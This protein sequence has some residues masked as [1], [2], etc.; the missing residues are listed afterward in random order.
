MLLSL[1]GEI[2]KEKGTYRIIYALPFLSIT[3]QVEEICKEIFRNHNER[4]ARIDSKSENT[5]FA[6][7][8]KEMDKNP[9]AISKIINAQFAE[10]LFDYPFI[11]TTFVKVFE[12]I[13]S[14][15]NSTL[16]KLPNFS[17]TIFLIDEIQSIPPRLYGFFVALLN[18][19]C[20]KFDSY[21]ILSTATMPNFE[22][23]K[24]NQHNLR[25]LFYNFS[26]PTELVSMNYFQSEVFNRYELLNHR[27]NIDID[28]LTSLV[29]KEELSTL[30]ILNTIDDTK[31][32][33]D[34]IC[35]LRPTYNPIL[36][37]THFTPVDRRRKIKAAKWFME[38]N[39]KVILISTQLIEAGVDIDFPVV[40]RDLAPIPNIIQSSGRCNRN[41]IMD[42]KGKVIVFELI[43]NEKS[44]A[45]IIYQGLDKEL[46]SSSRKSIKGI[47]CCESDLMKLQ[48]EYFLFTQQNLMFGWHQGIDLIQAIK[49]LAFEKLGHF[50]LIDKI[51]YGYE[52]Q[53]YIPRNKGDNN[54]EQLEQLYKELKTINYKDYNNKKLKWVEIENLMKKMSQR[55]LQIRLKPSDVPPVSDKEA[56]FQI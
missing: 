50:Q 34:K 49:E 5:L 52:V 21:V 7:Y 27:K 22:L 1:A 47:N 13:L 28:E 9:K 29:G 39:I 8:Q 16:L 23:P 4:I 3:E 11:I 2:L 38:R 55:I 25:N 51:K 56:C 36:L 14:N 54:F 35:E 41:G 48:K 42:K 43:R 24:N 32:L 15:K 37:N 12:T 17:K 46:L 20:K 44:R 53:Y 26:L 33:F 30:I 18:E 45:S 40:Y 31:K 6:K 19:F 10:D